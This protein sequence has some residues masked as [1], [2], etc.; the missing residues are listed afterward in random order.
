MIRLPGRQTRTSKAGKREG[1]GDHYFRSAWEAN[2][3]RYLNL[4]IK[5]KVV[6]R[7]E[8]ESE[9]FW[10]ENIKRGVRSYKPDFKVWYKPK[11][12][13]DP[14]YPKYQIHPVYVEVKGWMDAKSKTKIKR[15]AK[16]YPQHRLEVVDEKAYKHIKSQ[17]SGAI[18][19]WE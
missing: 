1:L 8:F 3:A 16:Y 12:Q 9:T 11:Y 13:T 4:L 18:K 17:W 6:D 5:M 14:V 2:Y 7:W 15:F 19:D 10:F